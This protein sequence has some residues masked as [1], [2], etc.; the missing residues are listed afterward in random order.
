MTL[1]AAVTGSLLLEAPGAADTTVWFPAGLAANTRR[2]VAGSAARAPVGRLV[3]VLAADAA[4][5]LLSTGSA[6]LWAGAGMVPA[7]TA[8]LTVVLLTGWADALTRGSPAGVA[9][10]WAGFSW[11]LADFAAA[12]GLTGPT[13]YPA[14]ATCVV[15]S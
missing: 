3:T 4:G 11:R 6:V 10:P 13:A 2:L 15:L 14:A 5:Y 9:A 7:V 8:A 12:A 1:L